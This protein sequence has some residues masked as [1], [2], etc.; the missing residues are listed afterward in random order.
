MLKAVWVGAEAF[1]NVVGASKAAGQQGQQQRAVAGTRPGTLSREEAVA[2]I[3][4]DYDVNYFIS[5]A[6]DMSAYAPD[7]LFAD[8]F[9]GFNG[10]GRFQ[11]NVSNLGGLM[12]NVNLTITSFDEAEQE[13][14][15]KWKFSATLDLPWKPVLAAAGG[16]THVFDQ[17]T[18]LVV[19]HI[20]SWDVEPAKVVRALLKPSA[21]V[22]G[23]FWEVLMS[24]VHDGDVV[25][26]WF[27]VS[28]RV[29]KVALPASAA[30]LVLHLARGEGLG[31]AEAAAYLAAV[32]GLGTECWKVVR[33]FVGG[34][35]G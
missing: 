35:S 21:K 18:G 14:R 2:A 15:T 32:G 10:V 19:K 4:K 20:E 23:T 33:A 31:T 1:G 9:A 26:M 24:A 3:R 5:G 7:C 28:S 11:R 6:G 27:A 16:T 12:Q 29:V 13:L 8:P 34:E 17:D 25:G 30:L 22:P